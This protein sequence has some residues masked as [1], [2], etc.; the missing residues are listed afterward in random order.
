M[1]STGNGGSHKGLSAIAISF[2]GLSSAAMRLEVIFPQRLQRWISAHSPFLRTQNP[3]R[4]HMAATI[5]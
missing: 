1:R 5:A 2:M 3:N 4:L